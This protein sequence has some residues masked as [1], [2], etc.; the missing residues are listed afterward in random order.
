MPLYEWERAVPQR[1]TV[2]LHILRWLLFQGQIR[3]RRKGRQEVPRPFDNSIFSLMLRAIGVILIVLGLLG[4]FIGGISVTT[5]ETVLDVGPLEV[6]EEDRRTIPIT[7]VASGI[8][9]VAGAGL[10]YIG[11]RRSRERQ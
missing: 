5:D 4:L 11:N 1:L 10:F 7:P 6:Q 8:A 3:F 9:L 2:H